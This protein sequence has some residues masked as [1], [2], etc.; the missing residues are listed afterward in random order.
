MKKSCNTLTKYFFS[1][2]FLFVVILSAK[3]SFAQIQR[4]L[5]QGKE[6]RFEDGK[7]FTYLKEE[8]GDEIIPQRLIVQLKDKGRMETFNFH[9]FKLQY[10]SLSS[11]R[12]LDG[13]YVLKIPFDQNPFITARTLENSGL[14]NVLS[15]DA[16]GK[17][18]SNPND[19]YY[20]DQWNLTKV[21]ASS[22]WDI[23]TGNS[24]IILAVI[25]SGTDY[26]HEDI[27]GNIWSN[28]IEANGDANGDGY[29]G[30]KNVD[31]DGDGLIDEDSEGRQPGDQ[32]Y[33]NDLI[34][35]DDENGFA[36]DFVGWDFAGGDNNP[37]PPY[38]PDNQP[39]D[40]DGHG[41]SVGGISCA[42]T[43]N[44]ESGVYLG[45]ASI[46]G[47]WGTQN[48]VS[49]MVL[50]DGG[51][52]P[53]YSLTATAIE[54]AAKN[55]A[56]VINLS[57]GFNTD[58]TVVRTAVNLAVNTYDVEIVAAAGNYQQGQSTSVRYPAAYSNVIAVG[59][60]TPDDDRKELNDG[61]ED[62]W[63]SCYG[64]QLFVTA[65]GV[66]IYTTDISGSA[67]YSSNNYFDSFNGTSS[68]APHISG[69]A[70]L[71][72]SINP[73]FTRQQ[74]LETIRFSADKVSGMGGQ[75]FTNEYGYGRINANKAVHNLYVP[76]V[77]STIESAFSAASPGQSVVIHSNNYSLSNNIV[78]P[79]GITLIIKNGASLTLN[80]Y[81][82]TKASTGSIVIENGV[83]NTPDIRLQ[84]GS[85]IEGLY[86][87]ISSAFT[88]SS[89]GQTVHLR[90][91]HTLTSDLT[92]ASD[93]GLTIKEGAQITLNDYREL[94]VYGTLTAIGT[95]SNPIVFTSADGTS[96]NSENAYL[97]RLKN[98]TSD[99]S[100]LQYCEIKNAVRGVYFDNSDA[101]IQ[102]C[103]VKNCTYG[104]YNYYSNNYIWN[105]EITN[106]SYGIYNYHSSPMIEYNEVVSSTMGLRC[107]SY[108]SPD[109]AYPSDG[110][111]YFHRSFVLFGVYAENN[112]NPYLGNGS[113]DLDWGR[114]TFDYDNYDLAVVHA[115][116]N[117]T[118]M[119]ENNYWGGS[120]PSS[121]MFSGD[122]DWQPYLTSQPSYNLSSSPEVAEF[123]AAFSSNSIESE[124]ME[125]DVLSFYDSGWTLKEKTR[126]IQALIHN[127]QAQSVHEMCKDI[128][129]EYPDSSEAFF[130][131]DLLY[132]A[133]RQKNMTEGKDLDSFK[134]YLLTLTQKKDKKTL[135]GSAELLLSALEKEKGLEK[136]D[137]VFNDY[138]QT[139]LAEVALFQK[140]MYYYNE[141]GDDKNCRSVLTEME[142]HFPSSEY[143]LEAYHILG[144]KMDENYA[145]NIDLKKMESFDEEEHLTSLPEKYEL[146]GAYPNPFNPSTTIQYALPLVS[147]VDIYIF[148]SLGQ[149][150]NHIKHASRNSGH[151][152]TTWNGT[153][154]N[155]QSV[156]SGIYFVK[157]KAVSLEKEDISFEESIKVTLIR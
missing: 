52:Q 24:S 54:Y 150:I 61:T 33:T 152:K 77:F 100:I 97:I 63:G 31:D 125:T 76:E 14:F 136:I 99:N 56:R 143:T 41:T 73:S 122:V 94:Y 5:L 114:N 151:W 118:I 109:L 138:R 30:I 17:R 45:V 155:G 13:F 90:G 119:A 137:N 4:F 107:D 156:P 55:G 65:P 148:N 8:K 67:G 134:D 111:N 38:Q 106:T 98:S 78:V 35:D 57:T 86:T 131:L 93:R 132:Q 23:T 96:G 79:A 140:F 84:T 81:T 116:T 110:H 25:D 29:P 32:G 34:N 3:D 2:V 43:N 128:I 68:S 7:W 74:V 71:I 28:P 80:S 87:T 147:K 72:R 121:G 9:Q 1:L 22:A 11:P 135:Y 91:V 39:L 157:F 89:S 10:V 47:G 75:D 123:N 101:K 117:C 92:V 104:I 126:F 51:A 21:D 85:T 103:E 42:Q 58:Y 50:R 62:W 60:T 130:A 127:D 133:S 153:N 146:E 113:C 112:S 48:G 70:A 115:G 66:Y 124:K 141:N 69:I 20:P 53:I 145:Y 129:N 40:T 154:Q 83:Q 26:N 108:S 139:Y 95:S 144:E 142:K 18:Y 44:Y 82:V 88:A 149:K 49:L 19:Q 16:Y 105:N 36:D 64:S 37:Q 27:D 120:N 102:N 15:F 12:F 46:A 6:Y 59:A